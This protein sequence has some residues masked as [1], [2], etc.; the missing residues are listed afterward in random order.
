MTAV[1]RDYLAG[2]SPWGVSRVRVLD[3]IPGKL[4]STAMLSDL[5][6]AGI[7]PSC[8]F[9]SSFRKEQGKRS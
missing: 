9:S 1:L 3:L 8:P 6:S 5:L 7:G 4:R 2:T